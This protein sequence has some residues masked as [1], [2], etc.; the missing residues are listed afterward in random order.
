MWFGRS[1]RRGMDTRLEQELHR[2][3]KAAGRRSEG[4]FVLEAAPDRSGTAGVVDYLYKSG[5]VLVDDMDLARV[6]KYLRGSRVRFEVADALIGGVT[7][8]RV[9]TDVRRLVDRAD[10][11]LGVGVVTPNHVLDV[12]PLA[13]LCPAD[14]P[15]PATPDQRW[16]TTA[17]AS[18]GS[19]V[20]VAVVDTGFVPG[21]ER[22]L[23]WLSGVDRYDVDDDVYLK[24]GRRRIAPYGGHG[25]FSAGVVLSLA[26]GA[27]VS[28]DDVLVGGVVDEATM[29]R[30][31]TESLA[32]SPDLICLSAGTYT[33]RNVPPKALAAFWEHRLRHH[34]GIALVAAAGN[35][36]SRQPFW[37]AAFP[38]ALGVGALTRTGSERASWSNHGGWVDVLAPGEDVVNAFPDG[39]YRYLDGSR[40]E[41]RHRMARWSGTSFSTP[42]VAGLLAAR[43]SRT[44]ENGREAAAALR[45][46]ARDNHDPAV[47]PR[48]LLEAV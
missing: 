44:G 46:E 23:P 20:R 21:H 19:G 10:A 39:T 47:G 41:F 48:V 18:L 25:T 43:M 40:A 28:V 17:D 15:R 30:Q 38:W 36:G 45:L 42:I 35:N 7:V 13:V 14:E 5:D 27:R 26:P 3:R 2:V 34:K 24:R 32:D 29:V 33:R 12:Q 1:A 16:P 37:P 9:R 11:A 4:A 31:L 8:L 6:E 22:A